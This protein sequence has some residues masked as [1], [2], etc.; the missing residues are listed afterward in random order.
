MENDN[1]Q[2][3][4]VSNQLYFEWTDP[5]GQHFHIQT[6]GPALTEGAWQYVTLTVSNGNPEIRVNGLVKSFQMYTGNNPN[7]A[8]LA[9]T[10]QKVNLR[11]NTLPMSIGKQNAG[12]PNEFYYQGDI[13]NLA[14][15]NRPL[16]ANEIQQ[17][18]LTYSA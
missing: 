13:G 6:N 4:A 2:L 17:N 18:L 15:Y 12:P 5:N 9:P 14:L 3:V 10:G 1:Y 16:T 7:S 8:G 11:D